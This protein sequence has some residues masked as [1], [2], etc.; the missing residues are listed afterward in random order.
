MADDDQVEALVALTGQDSTHAAVLLK[1][2]DGDV[3]LAAA[4]FFD[5]Q[6]LTAAGWEP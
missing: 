5:A 6:D 1:S 2:A 4:M 3:A